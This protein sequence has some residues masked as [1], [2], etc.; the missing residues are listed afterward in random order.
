MKKGLLNK[1][2]GQLGEDAAVA[3]LKS[4]KYKIIE[5]NYKNKIGEIDIIAKTGEDLVFV[6][7]K[8]RSSEKFGTPAE[9]VTYYK[10]QKIVN[11]AKWYISQNSTEL[12]IRFDIIE[13]YGKV[14]DSGFDLEKINHLIQVFQ[15]V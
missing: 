4:K 10:K 15:E 9:A 2:T 7:V 6:E 12:N 13:V 3:F 14:T 1:Q 8:T 5:R 11:A